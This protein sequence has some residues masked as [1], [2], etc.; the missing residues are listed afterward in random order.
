MTVIMMLQVTG[1]PKALE[2]FTSEHEEKMH[3]VL[4]AAKSHGLIG[5]RFYGSEDGHSVMVADEW[6]NREDFET[7]FREQESEIR[8]MFESAGVT[9]QVEPTFWQELATHDAYGWQR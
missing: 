3:A 6:P 2:Q 1:D 9:A 8:P 7:F 5:H 4:E